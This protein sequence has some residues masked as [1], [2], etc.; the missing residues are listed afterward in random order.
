M[1]LR[2]FSFHVFSLAAV[3]LTILAMS[4]DQALFT[5]WGMIHAIPLWVITDELQKKL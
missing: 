5:I 4:S 2:R 3:A 1:R